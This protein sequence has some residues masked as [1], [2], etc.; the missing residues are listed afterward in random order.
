MNDNKKSMKRPHLDPDTHKPG[1]ILLGQ[2]ISNKSN[3]W[4]AAIKKSRKRNKNETAKHIAVVVSRKCIKILW[5]SVRYMQ[6]SFHLTYN[7]GHIKITFLAFE[8]LFSAF[9]LLIL[10]VTVSKC[11]QMV[12][13]ECGV[14]SFMLQVLEIW[15]HQHQQCFWVRLTKKKQFFVY[16]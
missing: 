7:L 1:Y 12:I 2:I 10:L 15:Q 16:S 6:Y 11:N 8:L 5:M 3:K 9:F 13:F 14:C 4:R